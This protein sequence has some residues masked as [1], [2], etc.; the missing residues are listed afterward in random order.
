MKEL[1]FDVVIH[2]A[3]EQSVP[4]YM[5]VKLSDAEQH[6]L[7]TTAQ[8]RQQQEILAHMFPKRENFIRRIEVSAAD[9][10]EIRRQLE[11]IDDLE[12]KQVGVNITGGTK[13]MSTAALDFCRERHYVPFYLDTGSR[14]IHIFDGNYL[15]LPM[16]KVFN[17]VDEFFALSG[18]AVSKRGKTDADISDERRELIRLF[19]QN[20]DFARRAISD[21]SE[22]TDKKY[23]NQK[24]CP[25]SCFRDACDAL[26][27][28]RGKKERELAEKWKQVF[29]LDQSDWR[30]AAHFGAGEWFEEWTLLQFAESRRSDSFVDL[31]SDISLMY[32]KGNSNKDAQQIDVAY[33]DGYTL[34]LI[35]CKAGRVYQDH[36]Q[37][38]E[39]LRSK[40]GGAMGRGIICAINYQDERDIVV[41]RVKNGGISLVT[42]DQALRML[43]TRYDLVKPRHCYQYSSDYEQ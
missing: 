34:T 1:K 25:P 43:P 29:P 30:L 23:Q 35:E 3:G 9:Y 11:Q 14:K 37:K 26:L 22:A 18:F 13:P 33:T 27:R 6:V 5:A 2:L 15:Q 36:V 39:N 42:G 12:G 28:G 8:T 24:N 31:R 17:V 21:F 41:Q 7:V 38:L 32:A 20:R 19:W 10:L 4:N 40:V 16:P